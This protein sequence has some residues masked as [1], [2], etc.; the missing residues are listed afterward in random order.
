VPVLGWI[1]LKGRCYDCGKPI[2]IRY[3]AM[4]AAFGAAGAVVVL[5]FG[6]SVASLCYLAFLL[7][8][9]LIAWVDWETMHIYDATTFP[10]FAAGVL[11]SW[12]IPGNFLSP[13]DAPVASLEM[14][15]VMLCL[16]LAGGLLS[17]REAVGGGDLKLMAAGAAFLGT[18]EA[19]KALVIG[20]F[21]SLPIL[22]LYL[23]LKG[24]GRKDPAPFGPGL[25]AGL[26]LV[27][28]NLLGHG[29]LDGVFDRLWLPML[30]AH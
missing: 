28:W 11:F 5:H 21:A 19:W 1:F 9:I 23:G 8:L 29:E 13:L 27:G 18:Q 24:L 3:P 17:G 10:L 6:V 15:A 30:K 22:A 12:L 25:A 26:A 2:S 14:L 4:E 20:I 7:A 16:S